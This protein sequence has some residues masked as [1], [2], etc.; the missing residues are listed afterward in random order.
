MARP[1][2]EETPSATV[3]IRAGKSTENESKTETET[4]IAIAAL[5]SETI[6]KLYR[7]EKDGTRAWIENGP[8]LE[9]TE[10]RAAKHGP[11]KYR[12]MY[13]GPDP[14]NNN[15]NGYL[16]ITTFTVGESAARAAL[17]HV[18]QESAQTPVASQSSATALMDQLAGGM[19][20]GMLRQMQEM[21]AMQA[22]QSSE[23][24]A[25][26]IALI[27]QMGERPATDPLMTALLPK[28]FEKA[29]PIE[30]ATRIAEINAKAS[31]KNTI[32]EITAVMELIEKLR[33]EGGGGG[34]D[35]NYLTLIRD[36]L[37]LLFEQR[38]QEVQPQPAQI[39]TRVPVPVSVP[40]VP[41]PNN[42]GAQVSEFAYLSPFLPFLPRIQEAAQ[43]GMPPEVAAEFFVNLVPTN[44]LE[45]L[46]GILDR[47]SIVGDIAKVAPALAPFSG[48]LDRLRSEMLAVVRDDGAEDDDDEPEGG[49]GTA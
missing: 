11:G 36:A 42:G 25:A 13:W 3:E 41:V 10:E 19:L 44:Q 6:A 39:P 20:I 9:M 29:D 22:R 27:K 16:G 17:E 40:N 14:D 18:R 45:A 24:S 1:K 2:R 8:P 12:V 35:V 30:Q 28:L 7:I 21:S 48:W 26:M 43:A 38:Q 34:G 5:P 23:H 31:G 15:R 37:P 49:G 4:S 32:T 47:P 33:G 46:A